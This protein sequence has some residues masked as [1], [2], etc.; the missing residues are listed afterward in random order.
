MF[1][2]QIAKLVL[3][4]VLS[5]FLSIFF[6]VQR[7]SAIDFDK[8][9][10]LTLDE[11][12]AGAKKEGKLVWYSSNGPMFVEALIEGFR[13]VYPFIEVSY[14]RAGGPA[15]AQRFLAEKSRNI[16]VCDVFESGAQEFYPDFRKR[17]FFGRIDNLPEW[18]S[19]KKIA[20][21]VGGYYVHA[22]YWAHMMVWNRKVY[23]DEEVPADLWEFTKP[24]WKG[25][26]TTGDPAIAGFALNWYSFASGLRA[27]H[28]LS[29]A[30]P[31][32]LGLEWMVAMRENDLLLAGQSG[33]VMESLISGQR[34]V[35]L[36]QLDYEIWYAVKRG[37][38]LGYKVPIQGTMAQFHNFAVN[39][40]S[41]H[42][43]AARL[44][45]NWFLSKEGQI[46]NMKRSGGNTTHKDLDPS[47]V[48]KGRVPLEECWLLDIEKIT[49]DESHDFTVKINNALRGTKGLK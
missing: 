10:K 29:K 24:K 43:Y 48:H 35:L 25:K 38:N 46:E 47:V 31:A 19:V 44:L 6:L 11:L 12:I 40:E 13:E 7:S 28:P 49:A 22:A 30:K 45:I 33:N 36:Q 21:G 9:E 32:G 2:R 41:K 27:K 4:M 8:M 23:K 37:A 26:A 39:K 34:P 3:V 1:T 42:P 20:Q 17:G 15:I 5:M 16:E 18:H 14:I